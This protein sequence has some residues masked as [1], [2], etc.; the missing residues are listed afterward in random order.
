MPSE[1]PPASVFYSFIP[2]T[3]LEIWPFLA[4]FPMSSLCLLLVQSETSLLP[5][6]LPLDNLSRGQIFF[7]LFSFHFCWFTY[8]P[9]LVLLHPPPPIY[10]PFFFHLLTCS[11]TPKMGTA[12]HPIQCS[13]DGLTFHETLCVYCEEGIGFLNIIMMNVF[14]K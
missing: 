8:A 14:H 1:S 10:N 3:A 2:F 4:L 5:F 12:Y 11:T 6:T 9:V 13:H 7:T